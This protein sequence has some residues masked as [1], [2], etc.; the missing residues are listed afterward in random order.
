MRIPRSS[1][2][3]DT[4]DLITLLVL[5]AQNMPPLPSLLSLS[6]YLACRG[7]KKD[8]VVAID[9][10]TSCTA[11]SWKSIVDPA[12]PS[13]GVPDMKPNEDIIG[14]SPTTLLIAGSTGADKMFRPTGAEAYGREAQLRYANGNI[15]HG[16]QLFKR[17]KM[18]RE[19]RAPIFLC[20]C[21][22]LP[23]CVCVRP[24]DMCWVRDLLLLR[25]PPLFA[26]TCPGTSGSNDGMGWSA[27][28]AVV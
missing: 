7:G 14:K 18:V 9:L 2:S 24:D 23:V 8:F 21:S 27:G 10:G 16:A 12:G 5:S 3:T 20:Y 25:Q 11:F 13:V 1:S 26:P 15:P 17:F 6:S 19:R 28:T 4:L 22:A